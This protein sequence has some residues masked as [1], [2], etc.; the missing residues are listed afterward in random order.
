L[1]AFP[2]VVAEDVAWGDMDS[3]AHVSNIVFVRYFQNARIE[4]VTSNAVAPNS[5]KNERRRG[6]E[7]LREW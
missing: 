3:F 2:V 4:Y 5:S 1:T 7:T 6:M